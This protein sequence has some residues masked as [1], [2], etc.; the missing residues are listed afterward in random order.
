M[1]GS[2]PPELP[3]KESLELAMFKEG[4]K[5][6]SKGSREGLGEGLGEASGLELQLCAVGDD[7]KFA[8]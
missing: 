8:M 4:T 1:F 6:E 7:Q 3:P 2:P 5:E